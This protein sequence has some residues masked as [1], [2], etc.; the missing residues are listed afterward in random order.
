HI[1]VQGTYW[2]KII[3][4]EVTLVEIELILFLNLL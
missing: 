2:K 1:A 3:K 4:T